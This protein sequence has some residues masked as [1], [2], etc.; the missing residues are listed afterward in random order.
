MR[1]LCQYLVVLEDKIQEPREGYVSQHFWIPR[2][3]V[4]F[5]LCLSPM[6][7]PYC[8]VGLSLGREWALWGPEP[9]HLWENSVAFI[10]TSKQRGP[11]TSLLCGV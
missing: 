11:P 7:F 9:L 6:F 1:R 3:G 2:E 8:A 4:S 5:I 10:L